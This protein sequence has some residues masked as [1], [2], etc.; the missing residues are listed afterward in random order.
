MEDLDKEKDDK[1]KKVMGNYLELHIETIE[2]NKIA[3]ESTKKSTASINPETDARQFVDAT[4]EEWKQPEAIEFQCKYSDKVGSEYEINGIVST[5]LLNTH[6]KKLI[7]MTELSDKRCILEKEL[8]G[9]STLVASYRANNELGEYETV[10]EEYNEK[11]REIVLLDSEILKLEKTISEIKKTIPSECFEGT[12]FHNFK[13]TSFAISS[14]CNQCQT[15]VWGLGKVGLV[16]QSC[17]FVAHNRCEMKVPPK[18]GIVAP[19]KIK[20]DKSKSKKVAPRI[21]RVD[22]NNETATLAQSASMNISE[23]APIERI[24]ENEFQN[25][26]SI[27]FDEEDNDFNVDAK[28]SSVAVSTSKLQIGNE[29]L[30]VLYNY[31]SGN[32]DELSVVP[33]DTVQLIE[34]RG[35]G[36]ARVQKGSKNGLVPT[37]YLSTSAKSLNK[38]EDVVVALYDYEATSETDLS[39]KP[40][41]EIKVISRKEDGWWVGEINGIKG[42][43]PSNYVSRKE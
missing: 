40:G 32:P 12:V 11:L 39:L 42:Q 43:F 23:K 41:D 26:S 35:D 1:V 33:G 36:W 25:T 3:I 34:D 4:K 21:R 17:K 8:E 30:R 20:R 14:H 31:E 10:R 29:E 38:D 13:P 2:K 27:A 6:Q 37:N 22:S 16:C 7:E 5:F 24:K 19:V 18:C 9:L 15:S 28:V